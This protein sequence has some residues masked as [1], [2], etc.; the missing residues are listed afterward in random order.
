EAFALSAFVSV[1]GRPEVWDQWKLRFDGG[2]L[3]PEPDKAT[4]LPDA[5]VW[6]G[7]ASAATTGPVLNATAIGFENVVDGP[8]T[9]RMGPASAAASDGSVVT[10]WAQPPPP[11][12]EFAARISPRI[13]STVTPM[14]LHSFVDGPDKR[15]LGAVLPDEVRENARTSPAFGVRKALLATT[16]S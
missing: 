4:A 8:A 13:R 10:L 5:T 3:C 7:P 11:K 6:S 15:R 14:G 12:F 9:I 16:I 1:T 2:V